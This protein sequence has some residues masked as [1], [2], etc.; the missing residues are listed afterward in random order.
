[1]RKYFSNV[2]AVASVCVLLSSCGGGD[3]D[4]G[5][6]V[7]DVSLKCKQYVSLSDGQYSGMTID[8]SFVATWDDGAVF[9]EHVGVTTA[10]LRDGRTFSIT[11]SGTSTFIREMCLDWYCSSSSLRKSLSSVS[12]EEL[13]GHLYY[14]DSS[15]KIVYAY[16]F[17]NDKLATAS[18][19]VPVKYASDL[20]TYLKERYYVFDNPGSSQIIFSG[21]IDANTP[22]EA[23]TVMG[24]SIYKTVNYM[25]T[26]IPGKAV[27]RSSVVPV[28]A[29]FGRFYESLGY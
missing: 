7:S 6:P 9:G 12:L 16:K 18:I 25:V 27:T 2:L 14:Q 13:D 28:E 8:N 22:G 20:A 17:E 24:I 21:G 10:R 1:M 11:V 4:G 29:E 15:T 3:D 5:S 26:F 23:T 19:L